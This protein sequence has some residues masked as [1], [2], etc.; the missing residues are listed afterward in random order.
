MAKWWQKVSSV[1][2]LCQVIWCTPE[3]RQGSVPTKL[4]LIRKNSGDKD[5]C[6]SAATCRDARAPNS[7]MGSCILPVRLKASTVQFQESRQ[8]VGIKVAVRARQGYDGSRAFLTLPPPNI[9]RQAPVRA[10]AVAHVFTIPSRRHI[11]VCCRG[12]ATC[13]QRS[14]R[15]PRSRGARACTWPHMHCLPLPLPRSGTWP[16]RS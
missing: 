11:P 16:R 4:G 7:P 10:T 6:L 8:A 14:S 12:N 15:C 1:F 13:R 3:D 2:L 5:M 9:S